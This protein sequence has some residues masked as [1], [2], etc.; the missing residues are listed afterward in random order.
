MHVHGEVQLTGRNIA[1]IIVANAEAIRSNVVSLKS[2]DLSKYR[3]I[4]FRIS[5]ALNQPVYIAV[6]VGTPTTRLL[7]ADGTIVQYYPQIATGYTYHVIPAFAYNVMLSWAPVA[8]D[9]T[10]K[11][12]YKDYKSANAQ[13]LYKCEPA[14][15]TGT[16]TIELVGEPI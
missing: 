14:P 15:T 9:V 5:N 4:D 12:P 7:K 3:D 13:I 10:S 6:R 2:I 1:E 11:L 8:E 16:L